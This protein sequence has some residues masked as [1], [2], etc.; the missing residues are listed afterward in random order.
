[1]KDHLVPQISKKTTAEKMFRALRELFQDNNINHALA[2]RNQL[3]NLEILRLELVSSYSMRISELNNQLSTIG[4]LVSDK[5]LVMNTLNGLPPSWEALV[6]L[7]GQPRLI[8]STQFVC[9]KRQNLQ[10]EVG[11]MHPTRRKSSSYISC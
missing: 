8:V 9:K 7:D 5:E 11:Y 6:Y 10:R 2:L 4:D 1:M 3:L